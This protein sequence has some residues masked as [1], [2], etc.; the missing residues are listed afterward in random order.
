[1]FVTVRFYKLLEYRFWKIVPKLRLPPYSVFN[2]VFN[3]KDIGDTKTFMRRCDALQQVVGCGRMYFGCLVDG[4]RF[5][6]TTAK[7][8]NSAFFSLFL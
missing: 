5:L 1:M 2:S 8:F 4:V 6:L 7:L 3:E